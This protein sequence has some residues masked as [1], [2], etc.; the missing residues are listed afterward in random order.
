MNSN[1]RILMFVHGRTTWWESIIISILLL[2]SPSIRRQARQY[3]KV[4]SVFSSGL[5]PEN[6]SVRSSRFRSI[7]QRI[8]RIYRVTSVLALTFLAI[9]VWSPSFKPVLVACGVM[10]SIE[11]C[12]VAGSR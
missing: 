10:Q 9:L 7:D 12:N 8:S 2:I 11:N 3:A 4:S 5:M 6:G 1:A